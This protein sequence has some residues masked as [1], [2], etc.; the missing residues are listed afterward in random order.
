MSAPTPQNIQGSVNRFGVHQLLYDAFTDP[1]H[2]NLHFHGESQNR[3]ASEP[4]AWISQKVM[5]PMKATIDATIAM[6]AQ[7]TVG[8]RIN[9]QLSKW[10]NMGL[11]YHR[12]LRHAR[13][14]YSIANTAAIMSNEAAVVAYWQLAFGNHIERLLVILA[15]TGM[16][17]AVFPGSRVI[18]LPEHTLKIG[19]KTSVTQSGAAN[20]N[21]L[22]DQGIHQ[23]RVDRAVYIDY[24]HSNGTDRICV[25]IAEFKD[26]EIAD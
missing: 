10:Y 22:A 18:A 3:T 23:T 15:D 12:V 26:T 1:N 24:K 8:E 19:V 4:T 17:K 9:A 16:T 5:A 14:F 6:P 2:P 25:F 20:S 21:K 11:P 13:M 7:A